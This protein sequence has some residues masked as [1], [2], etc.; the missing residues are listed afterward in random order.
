MKYYNNRL[1]AI[2][3]QYGITKFYDSKEWRE[4]KAILLQAINNK[5]TTELYCSEM[6]LFNQLKHLG[7][8]LTKPNY[9]LFKRPK[10]IELINQNNEIISLTIHS[11]ENTPFTYV[12]INY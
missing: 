2:M 5:I 10:T 9:S 6:Q 1:N 3:Q 11:I 12:R 4:I 7:Y 8:K